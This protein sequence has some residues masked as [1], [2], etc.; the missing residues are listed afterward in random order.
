MRVK[1]L[2]PQARFCVCLRSLIPHG[3]PSGL[4]PVP[5]LQRWELRLPPGLPTLS[6]QVLALGL[7]SSAPGPCFLPRD[8][9]LAIPNVMMALSS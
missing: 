8:D 3:N 4:A 5:T 6:G 1:G 7:L 2:R 9:F